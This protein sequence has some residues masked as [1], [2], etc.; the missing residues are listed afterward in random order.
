MWPKRVERFRTLVTTESQGINPDLILSIIKQESAGVIGRKAGSTC[1]SHEIPTLDGGTIMY[2]R[3]LGLMQVVPGTIAG[4][5]KR[6]PHQI[7]YF[8]Q[9]SGKNWEDARVQIRVGCDVL[10]N[11]YRK[12]HANYPKAFPAEDPSTTNTNQLLCALLAY[13]RGFGALTNKFAILQN[14]D[15]SLTYENIKNEF[16]LWGYNTNT[17]EWINRVIHYVDTVWENA[18]NSGMDPAGTWNQPP[19]APTQP[20]TTSASGG[21]ILFFV[22]LLALAFRMRT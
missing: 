17:G 12:L 13:R 15:L 3:A 20:T 1:R 5:N 10:A 4:Y 16:P 2:N 18:L 8:E 14:R 6:N 9:M 11:E 19:T 7:A 21:E 22:L